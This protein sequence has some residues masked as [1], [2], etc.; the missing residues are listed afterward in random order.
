V[1]GWGPSA[2]D[3][4]HLDDSSELADDVGGSPAW[5]GGKD[6]DSSYSAMV[7][8]FSDASH[9]P[10][11]CISGHSAEVDFHMRAYQTNGTI[12]IIADSYIVRAGETTSARQVRASKSPRD[13]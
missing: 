2:G 6:L 13:S 8:G 9:D 11:T 4:G 1:R 10:I 3:A 12:K 5:L 7:A